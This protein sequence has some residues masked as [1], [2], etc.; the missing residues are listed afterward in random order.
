[1]EK[2]APISILKE[3]HLAILMDEIRSLSLEHIT[4]SLDV[5]LTGDPEQR[6]FTTLLHRESDQP[7]EL[8]TTARDIMMLELYSF[9]QRL[10]S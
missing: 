9:I 1:M 10:L 2:T 5:T 8:Y 3:M 6:I 4:K 7:T